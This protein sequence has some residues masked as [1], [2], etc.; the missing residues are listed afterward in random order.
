MTKAGVATLNLLR[1]LLLLLLLLLILLL[2]LLVNYNNQL[3]FWRFLRNGL[4]ILGTPNIIDT[5]PIHSEI[6]LSGILTV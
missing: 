1:I 3:R 4:F 2:L 5:P 6:V